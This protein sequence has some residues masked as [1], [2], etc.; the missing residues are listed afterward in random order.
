MNQHVFE[1]LRKICN[2]NYRLIIDGSK[3]VKENIRLNPDLCRLNTQP[4]TESHTLVK[5]IQLALGERFRNTAILKHT[6]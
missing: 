5:N 6:R 1:I 3:T 2:I 4:F